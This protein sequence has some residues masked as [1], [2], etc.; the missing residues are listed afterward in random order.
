MIQASVRGTLKG[1]GLGAEE[2]ANDRTKP[3]IHTIQKALQNV[4]AQ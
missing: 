3:I 2:T 1:W 4:R